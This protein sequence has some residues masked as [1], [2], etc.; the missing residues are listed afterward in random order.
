MATIFLSS[1]E[2]AQSGDARVRKLGNRILRTAERCASYCTDVL[3]AEAMSDGFAAGALA[4]E[5]FEQ[6]A[7]L[8]HGGVAFTKCCPDDLVLNVP[9]ASLHRILFN[10]VKNACE[11]ME[12]QSG[13]GHVE[14]CMRMAG[15][16]AVIEVA[17]TGPGFA[18][19]ADH[20]SSVG[21]GLMSANVLA[22]KLGGRLEMAGTGPEGTIF[23]LTIPMG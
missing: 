15:R 1:E 8:G 13:A 21:V 9:Y 2:L 23:R 3:S 17:D 22:G 4:T 6:V 11:A 16:W 7:E 12:G 20:A 5:V 14:I 10:L 19:G 18:K